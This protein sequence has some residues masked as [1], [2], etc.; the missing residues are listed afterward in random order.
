MRPWGWIPTQSD[1]CPPKKRKF[2]HTEV[3]HQR[4]ACKDHVR[5][6]Q[7]G[8][9]LQAKERGLRGNQTHQHFHPG[10][11]S[12]STEKI[13]CLLFRPPALWHLIM[14]ALANGNKRD[15]RGPGMM[16]QGAGG[17]T[18]RSW[19][20]RLWGAS[21]GWN[22]NSAQYCLGTWRK[23]FNL[24]ILIPKRRL[25]LENRAHPPIPIIKVFL[26]SCL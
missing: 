6:Q 13:K 14:A 2:A 1:W 24:L 21:P 4:W 17:R 12:F 11:F 8:S 16:E 5:T 26:R 18:G 10:L 7:G 20:I 3:R 19:K 22:R 23:M 15:P 25:D 9:Q